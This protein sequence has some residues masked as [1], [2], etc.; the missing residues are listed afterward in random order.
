MGISLNM[1][2]WSPVVEGRMAVMFVTTAMA[3]PECARAIVDLSEAF[4]QDER[5]R[6]VIGGRIGNVHWRTKGMD[7]GF[8]CDLCRKALPESQHQRMGEELRFWVK[9]VGNERH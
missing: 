6:D 8:Q 5:V 1:L 2:N 7:V 3:C 9:E 4:I